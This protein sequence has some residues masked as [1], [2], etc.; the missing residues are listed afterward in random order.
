MHEANH[1]IMTKVVLFIK[2]HKNGI[3]EPKLKIHKYLKFTTNI[4]LIKLNVGVTMI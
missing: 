1:F 3:T 4:K 2:S